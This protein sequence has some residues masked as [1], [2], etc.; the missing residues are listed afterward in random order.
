PDHRRFGTVLLEKFHHAFSDAMFSLGRP[1]FV[2]AGDADADR[3]SVP[4]HIRLTEAQHQ[5]GRAA[6]TVHIGMLDKMIEKLI[7]HMTGIGKR[8][9][10]IGVEFGHA[11]SS[12]GNEFSQPY[13]NI[14]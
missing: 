7:E 14:T 11:P 1:G 10:G 4:L 6:L 2:L 12:F 8:K 3:F 13:P 9:T 5:L